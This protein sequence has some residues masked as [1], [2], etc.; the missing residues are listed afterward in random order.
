[1]NFAEK[2]GVQAGKSAKNLGRRCP[3][4]ENRRRNRG[5]ENILEEPLA[6]FGKMHY[7]D[8]NIYK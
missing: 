7:N 1:M 6:F 8:Y 2:H 3:A 4:A 5:S